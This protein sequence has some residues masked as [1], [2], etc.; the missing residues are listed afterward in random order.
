[1]KTTVELADDLAKRARAHAAKERTTLRALVERGLH[2]VLATDE[3]AG[4][5]RLRDASV[6]GRGL[7]EAFQGASW[8]RVREA[9]YGGRGG[10]R[11]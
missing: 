9:A 5:F 1:M 4:S 6:G 11:H 2:H 3:Q 10:P 7:S 8:N